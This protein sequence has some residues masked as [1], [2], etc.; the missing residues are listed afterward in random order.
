MLL[1]TNQMLTP[2]AS[3]P[4]NLSQAKEQIG[5]AVNSTGNDGIIKALIE[6]ATAE[7]QDYSGRQFMPA[8][9]KDGVS[10]FPGEVCWPPKPIVLQRFTATSL[11]AFTYLDGDGNTVDFLANVELIDASWPSQVRLSDPQAQWPEALLRQN[12]VQI[13]YEASTDEQTM[14]RVRLALLACVAT[15]FLYRAKEVDRSIHHVPSLQSLLYGL[16]VQTAYETYP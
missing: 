2:P 9:F 7:L 13:T 3:L 10:G 11:S 14:Y 8:T 6:T 12:T 5:I 1:Y 15:W 16:K 4:V